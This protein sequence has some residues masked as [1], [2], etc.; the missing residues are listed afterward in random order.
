MANMLSARRA[1][2]VEAAGR[3]QKAGLIQYRRGHIAVL[4]RSRLE[5]RVCEC[6]GSELTLTRP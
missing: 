2:V 5:A 1:G 3:L 4:D 6:S